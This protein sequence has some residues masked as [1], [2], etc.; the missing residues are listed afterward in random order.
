MNNDASLD[1]LLIDDE[2]SFTEVIKKR[3]SKRGLNVRVANNG[4]Q[5]VREFAS[6]PAEVI[7]LDMRMPEM[8][9]VDT[10]RAILALEPDAQVI[11]LTGHVNADRALEGLDLGAFDYCL[12]PIDIDTLYD[13]IIDAAERKRLGR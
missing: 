8:D 2:T 13:K 3:L 1:V 7:V 9:G 5:G 10:L 4:E 11:F 12:K 6:N